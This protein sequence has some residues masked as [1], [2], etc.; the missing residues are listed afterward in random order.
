MTERIPLV[1]LP[2]VLLREDLWRDQIA[3]LSDVAAPVVYTDH[4]EWE[5]MGEIAR[6]ILAKA[7]PRFAL[8]GLSMGGAVS[9]EIM[10]QAP[11]RVL[12]LALLDANAGVD[13]PQQSETRRVRME[14][15]RGQGKFTGL[16]RKLFK[17]WVH[18]DFH[19]DDVLRRRVQAMA[20]ATGADGFI[21]QY[22]AL[23]AR[24]D[25]RPDLPHYRIPTTVICGTH[26]LLTPMSMAAEMATLIPRAQLV[27]IDGAGHL[28]TMEQPATVSAA[29][30]DWLLG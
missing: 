19:E 21:R 9:F 15:A 17:E 20:E 7:P 11:D 26:D 22:T 8:A 2:G 23:M 1:L 27:P 28:T 10:R 13:T 18:P 4:S 25:S 24:P 12:R 30:R 14:M 29:M 3:A 5:T 6:A 16:S